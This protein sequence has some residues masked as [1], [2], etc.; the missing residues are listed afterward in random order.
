[1]EAIVFDH[2]KKIYISLFSFL[3]L[4]FFHFFSTS[5]SPNMTEIPVFLIIVTFISG[6]LR[7][8]IAAL[9]TSGVR[10]L[11]C[12]GHCRVHVKQQHKSGRQHRRGQIYRTHGANTPG[13]L[14]C[15]S[16]LGPVVRRSAAGSLSR[17]D[18]G[19]TLRFDSPFSLKMLLL[20]LL[21]HGV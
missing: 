9:I 13:T 11:R 1:M 10:R 8:K 19:S 12:S 20:L 2:L 14:L 3:F 16:R 6:G 17:T 15:W 21:F 4:L 7:C 18:P 5:L